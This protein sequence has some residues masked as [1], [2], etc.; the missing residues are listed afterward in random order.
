MN[1][2]NRL[3]II[4]LI[5]IVMILIPVILI[6]PERTE[7][8]L[9]YGAALI[10]ENLDWLNGLSPVAQVGVRLA[11]AAAGMIVFL[12]G[13]L[14]LALEVIRFR[15]STV[16]LRDGSGELMMDGVAGYLVYYVD[17]LPDVLRVKPTVRSKGRSVQATLYVETA[18]G[19]NVLEKSG[20]VRET[21]R[22]VLEEQLGLQV[23]GEIGVI[24]KP[25]PHPKVRRSTERSL[26]SAK[27]PVEAKLEDYA[28]SLE[29][30][31][32]PQGEQEDRTI[33]VKGPS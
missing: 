32:P 19:V 25:V 26:P 30:A 20:E 33:K 23:N 18:P 6:F 5:L 9:Q 3:V 8:V 1:I 4:L 13:L 24:I 29:L 7:Y 31:E 2:F 21:A 11:L 15:R 22:Q 14:L 17:L 16:R 12:I 27:R 10:Q 28:P